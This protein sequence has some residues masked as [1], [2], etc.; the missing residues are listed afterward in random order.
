MPSEPSDF[1]TAVSARL[2]HGRVLD[3]A[4]GSGRN[5]RFFTAR[6]DRVIGIDRSHES[7]LQAKAAGPELQTL[8]ADL[9]CFPLPESA[10][11]VVLNVRYLQRSLAPAL[12]RAL[13]PGGVLV[14]ETFL[15]DQLE[16]G[17]PRNPAFVL[18]HN[19]L[20]GLFP[21]LRVLH[22]EEGLFRDGDGETWLAR[23]LAERRRSD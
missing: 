19:E 20:L 7:L 5:A 11:D 17:H 14:F 8:E 21:G 3:V 1:L 6:G 23:L 18:Q 13:R 4:C 15:V 9:E 2:P 22:Y 12:A 10:F 16:R